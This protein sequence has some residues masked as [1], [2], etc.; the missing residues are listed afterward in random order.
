MSAQ[1]PLREF[2]AL[3]QLVRYRDVVSNS[4]C[5][6]GALLCTVSCAQ[7]AEHSKMWQAAALL[8]SQAEKIQQCYHVLTTMFPENAIRKM[9]LLAVVHYSKNPQT[10]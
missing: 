10:I 6:E 1:K 3:F 5:F 2:C 7:M 8:Y 4:I 9:K